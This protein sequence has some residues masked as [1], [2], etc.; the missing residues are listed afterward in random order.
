MM[1]YFRISLRL[2]FAVVMASAMLLVAILLYESQQQN[3]VADPFKTVE[4]SLLLNS[5]KELTKSV[6]NEE[7]VLDMDDFHFTPAPRSDSHRDDFRMT[8]TSSSDSSER[9]RSLLV[10]GADR[11]GTTF[12][13][14]MFSEDPQVF[15]IYEPLWVTKRWRK[16]KP[17]Q[18]WSRSELEV[19]NGILS[20]NFQ[21]FPMATEFLAHTSRNWAAA[22][23]KNPFQTPN[24]CNVSDTDR[25]SC[26]DLLHMPKFA[27]E[28]CATK[29]KHSVTKV[30]QVRTPDKLLSSLV[31]QLFSENPDTDIRI[32]QI[33]RDPRG[34]IDS[35]IKLHWTPKHT[36][37]GFLY[38][39]KYA[40]EKTTQNVKYAR[41][42]P[43]KYRDKYMEVYYR[44]IAMN[45]VK[46]A[47]KIYR[48][49]GFEISEDLIKWIVFNTSPSEE[50]LAREAKK[51]FSSV[52]N[53]TANIEKWR[54]APAEQNRLIERECKELMELIGIEN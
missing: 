16:S 7:V 33:L 28:A 48:F 41:N 45:P 31:P 44:D 23:F 50:A 12:I 40:C 54:S 9:R 53:S 47:L 26:P 17:E 29:Y 52:R 43:E 22:P 27:Q 25:T 36:S 10:F 38:Q 15:M 4:T 1:R 30:A 51:T 20:C 34:S 8:P 37:P 42:L 11:S 2:L 46:T 39:V 18:D 49:A 5:Q 3:I 13:S 21:D 32:L 6:P 14:R 35:R 24:F 19:L